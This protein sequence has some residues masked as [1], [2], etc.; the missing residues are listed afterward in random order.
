M[1]GGVSTLGAA[2][3]IIGAYLGWHLLRTIRKTGEIDSKQ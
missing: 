3:Y 2:G 1:I